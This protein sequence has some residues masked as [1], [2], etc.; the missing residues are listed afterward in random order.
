MW[1]EEATLVRAAQCGDVKAFQALVEHYSHIVMMRTYG[2]TG[3]R[4]AG[5]DL[6][7]DTFLRALK[8]IGSLK[9]VESFGVWLL[10]IADNVCR[11]HAVRRARKRHI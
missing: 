5:E 8:A 10:M 1:Q 2:S 3:E 7:Q 4:S 11:N 9:K 6:A